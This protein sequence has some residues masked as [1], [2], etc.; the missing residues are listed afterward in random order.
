MAAKQVL[1]RLLEGESATARQVAEQL[2][3]V[4]VSD[5]SAL[6][7]ICRDVMSAHPKELALYRDTKNPKYI[8]FFIGQAMRASKGSANPKKVQTVLAQLLD[9]DNQP[10]E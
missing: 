10:E 1:A 3:L 8:K 5:D 7:V 2:G 6:E 4:Q 9:H